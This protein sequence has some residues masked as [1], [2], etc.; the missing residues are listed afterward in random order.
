MVVPEVPML[1]GE[2][3]A[4]F[5]EKFVVT[6]SRDCA[7]G[8]RF[9]RGCHHGVLVHRCWLVFESANAVGGLHDDEDQHC[10]VRIM[11]SD[12]VV[13]IDGGCLSPRHRRQIA[14]LL[15]LLR[16]CHPSGCLTTTWIPTFRSLA[17]LAAS[18]LSSLP[19]FEETRELD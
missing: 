8:V 13:Q 18:R 5:V 1:E 2:G 4:L 17:V 12:A 6:I 9:V 14:W 19:P 10:E 15:W 7:P 3:E 11:K 16:S